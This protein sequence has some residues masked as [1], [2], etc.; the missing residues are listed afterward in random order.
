MLP[1]VLAESMA[2]LTNTI[3]AAYCDTMGLRRSRH[4]PRAEPLG[5]ALA[6]ALSL[7]R[8]GNIPTALTVTN[9]VADAWFA[10]S[11]AIKLWNHA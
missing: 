11:A 10:G 7:G 3:L 9:D 1:L 8:L 5:Y 6:L 2:R 4:L